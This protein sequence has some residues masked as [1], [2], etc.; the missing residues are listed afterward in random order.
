MWG[1]MVYAQVNPPRHTFL[2]SRHMKLLFSIVLPW[3]LLSGQ[4]LAKPVIYYA[5]V[6]YLGDAKH[7]D[8]SYPVVT[9]INRS[10]EAGAPAPLDKAFYA[11]LQQASSLPFSITNAQLGDYESGPSI[12]MTLAIERE[13]VSTDRFPNHYKL[14]AEISAQ[15]LF[16]DFQSMRL[17][18][19]IPLDIARNDVVNVK[20]DL[21]KAKAMNLKALYQPNHTNTNLFTLARE[22]IARFTLP[23]ENMLRFQVNSLSF[24]DKAKPLIPASVNTDSLSQAFG[25]YF[26][27]QLTQHARL[28]MI[29][30]TKGYAIGNKMSGRMSNGDVYQLSPPEPDYVFDVNVTNF[31]TINKASKNLYASRILLRAREATDTEL[32]IDDHL[33]FAVQMLVAENQRAETD[34]PGYEDAL[35][36]LLMD[37]ARQLQ[38][39]D[40]NW[41]N[42]HSQNKRKTYQ[43]FNSWSE[44]FNDI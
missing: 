17:I 28:N 4:V 3:W 16:F 18:A 40:K 19:S 33:H 21:A 11:I 44:Q 13:S 8:T 5:G 20:G 10:P 12:A 39:P 22:Q 42:T 25:Q 31:K 27:A 24:S 26:T 2:F 7:A 38:Q 29:P 35:E 15:I 37:I 32:L 43:S 1:S 34:W 14:V 36:M 9:S 6:S 30:Y 23:E 41:F